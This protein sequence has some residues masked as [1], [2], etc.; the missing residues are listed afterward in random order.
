MA[1]RHGIEG[2]QKKN[3]EVKRQEENR[4]FVP[5]L[6]LYDDGDTAIFRILNDDP[7]DIDFHA[8]YNGQFNEIYFCSKDDGECEFCEDEKMNP[9]TRMFMLWLYVDRILHLYQNDEKSWKE[10]SQGGRTYYEEPVKKVMFLR[11]PFGKEQKFWQPFEDIW[12]DN[13]T[14][15]DREFIYRRKGARRDMNTF[16]TLTSRDKSSMPEIVSKIIG[17][18]PPLESIAKGLVTE[19]KFDLDEKTETV[20]TDSKKDEKVKENKTKKNEESNDGDP[21]IS[22]ELPEI[23]LD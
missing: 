14:W 1:I 13:G 7:K 22:V 11:R 20:K 12:F 6:K 4:S 15:M 23:D 19:L 17:Q 18:L 2:I 5:E 16:Y 3:E 10:I 8:F 21:K 9:V